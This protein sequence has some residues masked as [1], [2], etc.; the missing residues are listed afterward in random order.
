MIT[1]D[2]FFWGVIVVCFTGS[3]ISDQIMGIEQTRASTILL[4]AAW[5][6]FFIV[7]SEIKI[8]KKVKK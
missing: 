2:Q 5:V 7:S 8:K 4:I 1:K 6:M 3:K